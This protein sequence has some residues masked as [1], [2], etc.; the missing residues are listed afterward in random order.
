MLHWNMATE[1]DYF[2]AGFGPLCTVQCGAVCGCS[3]L[4]SVHGE[5]AVILEHY[6]IND[7][8]YLLSICLR[9]STACVRGCEILQFMVPANALLNL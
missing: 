2:S 7:V 3:L 6:T 8:F 5:N 4:K 9:L 1:G